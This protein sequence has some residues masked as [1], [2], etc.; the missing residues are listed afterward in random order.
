MGSGIYPNQKD[1]RRGSYFRQMLVVDSDNRLVQPAGPQY[2]FET[3]V[4][5][6]RC[7]GLVNYGYTKKFRMGYSFLYGGP[8]GDCGI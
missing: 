6:P 4:D 5:R 1:I 8:G 7:Y 3:F 2:Q